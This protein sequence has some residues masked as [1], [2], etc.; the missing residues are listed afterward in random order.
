MPKENEQEFLDAVE[1]GDVGKVG[2]FLEERTPPKETLTLALSRASTKTNYN[3]LSAL[4]SNG[5]EIT[6]FAVNFAARTKSIPI[7]ELFLTHGWN[8]NDCGVAILR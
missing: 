8:I 3:I 4:L 2:C 1:D 6:R 7:F 5:A